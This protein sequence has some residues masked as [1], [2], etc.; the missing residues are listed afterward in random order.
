MQTVITKDKLV[1]LISFLF[2]AV[3]L[4][5][6]A[7]G[8][9]EAHI[10]R[11]LFILFS[12]VL[13]FLVK[14]IK[15]GGVS[16]TTEIID[17]V[18][19]GLSIAAVG[20]FILNF[21]SMA[22]R[23][24][25]P[26]TTLETILG[27]L[28]ILLVLEATRRTIGSVMAVI[29]ILFILYNFFGPYMPT[30]IAHRGYS[31][32]RILS[33]MYGSTSGIFGSVVYIF[34]SFIFLFILFGAFIQKSGAGAFFIDLS[35]SVVGRFT[36]GAGQA[37]VIS[38][39]FLGS[40][41]GSSTANTAVTGSITIPLM[42]NNGYKKH[43]AASVEAV[44]SI[45]GQ[46]LPPV[47]GAAAFLIASF[48]GVPYI[49]VA[50][51]GLVPALLFFLSMLSMVY[52]EAKRTGLKGLPKEEIPSL[53]AVLKSGWYFLVPI[54]VIVFVLSQGYSPSLA[55]F[56]A[57]VSTGA[58]TIFNKKGSRMGPKQV[59]E[60]MVD[61]S[62]SAITLTMTA[63]IIG[64]LIAA[65]SL[66]G[67]GLRMSTIILELSSGNLVIALILVMI[68]SFILG[69]GMNVTSA[70]LLLSTLT[71]P[72]L[73]ELG[74]PLL[75]AHFFVFWTSQLAVVTP[76]VALSAYVAAALAEADPMKTG[77]YSL[78][79]GLSIYYIPILFVFIPALLSLGTPGEIVLASL[80]AAL[81]VFIFSVIMQGYLL[82][83][84]NLLERILL[85]V[86]AVS[87]AFYGVYSDIVGL[88]LSSIVLTTQVLRTKKLKTMDNP[89]AIEKHKK[90][91]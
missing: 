52:L 57:I 74:V 2:A 22:Q 3:F 72:A 4:Y 56:W 38:S 26:L 45:G 43:V 71:A 53:K 17:Y 40:V 7:F 80:T 86:A 13:T 63:G 59:Y 68:A 39:G 87:L 15:K 32:N 16:K 5:Q 10:S 82:T 24:G 34:S 78:R 62:K 9:W 33:V 70:Y 18:C 89:I 6:A 29:G 69:M 58:V 11:G 30:I 88:L 36:G 1:N 66:P 60:A 67:L 8:I 28:T 41:M 85:V 84:T 42:I 65:I 21:P 90:V 77:W 12:L 14:P 44:V 64:I 54:F 31:L 37:A 19:V 48:T 75:A 91:L 73:V 23:A 83:K 27:V 55:G 47:M 61:G 76:P 25:L 50:V 20:Y 79:M 49:E 35:K 51:A 81:A 46:F